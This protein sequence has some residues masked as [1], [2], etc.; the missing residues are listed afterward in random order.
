MNLVVCVIESYHIPR[1]QFLNFTTSLRVRPNVMSADLARLSQ[2]DSASVR[3][4]LTHVVE[5]SGASGRLY[6]V[7]LGL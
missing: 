6:E 5:E 2:S 4:L 7:D 1:R 3:D